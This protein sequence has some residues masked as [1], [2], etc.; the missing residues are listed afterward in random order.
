MAT[1]SDKSD[2]MTDFLETFFGRSSAIRTDTCVWCFR[3]ATIF[4][5]AMSRKEYAIS[6]L[7]QKCQ[8]EVFTEE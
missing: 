1:P 3:P 8:D 7:C 2:I 4:R 6:G 5:D